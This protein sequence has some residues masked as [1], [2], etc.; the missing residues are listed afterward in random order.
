M[1]HWSRSTVLVGTGALFAAIAAGLLFGGLP[2][3]LLA[4]S[5]LVNL[6]LIVDIRRLFDWVKKPLHRPRQ[7]DQAW[8][9]ALLALHLRLRRERQRGRELLDQLRGLRAITRSLP[10]AAVSTNELGEILSFNPAAASLLRLQQSDIGT[11][12]SSLIR[13]PEFVALLKGQTS[14]DSVE[15]MSPFQDG[16]RLEARWLPVSQ[17]QSLVVVRN[18]TQLNKLLTMR[19]DFIANVSH[20]LRTPLTV[21]KGYLEA[22]GDDDL[23][24]EMMKTIVDRLHSPTRRMQALVDDL[25]LLTRLES[26]PDISEREREHIDMRRVLEGVRREAQVLQ[27]DNQLLKVSIESTRELN[28]V[29][30]E[31]HSAVTNLVTNALRYS[32]DGGVIA[33]SWRDLGSTESGRD[34][35]AELRIEDQGVG[36]ASE[37]ISRI[38]ERFYRVDMASA[39]VRGG[40]GLGLAIVKHV[41]KRHGATLEVESEIG[42]GSLFRC[43]FPAHMLVEVSAPSVQA[44]Q[45]ASR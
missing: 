38:T 17:T 42:V 35:G 20:E 25:L 22:L 23:P 12:L 10:D 8:Q 33:L 14:E 27:L 1:G 21:V 16:Q 2:W 30:S 28:G 39:R 36:I 32:P 11:S 9:R 6:R 3:W 26:A 15:M 45:E 34:G 19:Q 13:H 44:A 7:F 43:R 37:H 40:T 41:L 18:V 31:I 24:P 29:E 5:A 4:F